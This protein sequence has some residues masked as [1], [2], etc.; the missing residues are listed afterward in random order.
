MPTIFLQDAWSFA[1]DQFDTIDLDKSTQI[2]DEL[3]SLYI[4]PNRTYHT[5]THIENMVNSIYELLKIYSFNN[6]D[7]RKAELIFAAFFHDAI[8]NPTTHDTYVPEDQDSDE[9][10]SAKIAIKSLK[11]MGLDNIH[12]LSHIYELIALTDGHKIDPNLHT[13]LLIQEIFVDSDISILGAIKPKYYE[14]KTGIWKEYTHI[15]VDRFIAGRLEFLTQYI[16]K[17][18]IFNTEYMNQMYNEQAYININGEI[19]EL[20]SMNAEELIRTIEG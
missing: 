4:T 10:L 15:N 12:S 5:I 6:H 18:A 11:F 17:K 19:T 20:D 7:I 2:Y 14:Y 13:E 9:V 1:I 16:K 3:I 8:Y